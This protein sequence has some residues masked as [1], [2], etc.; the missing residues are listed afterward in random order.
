[1]RLLVGLARLPALLLALLLASAGLASAQDDPMML[2][3]DPTPLVA[4]T[5]S[6][7]RTFQ[8]EIADTADERA[9]GL[10]FR[11]QLPA[12]RG[13]LFVFEQTQSVGFWMENTPLPLDLLFVSAEGE[14]EAILQG[15]PL[16]RQVI[17]PG[18]PVRFVLEL[19]AGTAAREGIVVGDRLAHPIIAA[20][21]G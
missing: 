16:S 9:R 12:D 1:M 2:P 19:N 3:V 21:G 10:M 15:E 5:A 14:V 20:A 7:V 13:M 17:T 18:V 11:K 6:G 4:S 8:I